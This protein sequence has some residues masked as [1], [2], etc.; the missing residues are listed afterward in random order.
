MSAG[1]L[2]LPGSRKQSQHWLGPFKI[3]ARVAA[4]AYRLSLP[5]WLQG[6]YLTLH[7]GLLK[8][9]SVGGDGRLPEG[10]WPILVDG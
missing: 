1:N 8:K 7:L 9:H 10:P 5:E 2:T 4:V 3:L 6:I